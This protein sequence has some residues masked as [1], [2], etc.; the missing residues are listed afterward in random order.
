MNLVA[1][2]LSFVKDKKGLLKAINPGKFSILFF[3]LSF[4]FSISNFDILVP[5]YKTLSQANG[6][7]FNLTP[8]YKV[9]INVKNFSTSF[10]LKLSFISR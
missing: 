5:L 3:I 2:S 8:S 6:K 4:I 7:A 9:L 10:N 1:T